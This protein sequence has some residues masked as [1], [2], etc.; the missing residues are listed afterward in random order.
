M[1]C[2]RL[3]V[4]ILSPR[5]P[6]NQGPSAFIRRRA[7]FVASK[8]TLRQ[9]FKTERLKAP[10]IQEVPLHFSWRRKGLAVKV[11]YPKVAGTLSPKPLKDS[12]IRSL[13]CKPRR[14]IIAPIWRVN[15][16]SFDISAKVDAMSSDSTPPLLS[17]LWGKEAAVNSISRPFCNC[18]MRERNGKWPEMKLHTEEQDTSCSAWVRLLELIEQ[19]AN[20]NREEFSPSREMTPEQW[21]QIITLPPS[22]AKLKAVKHFILYGSSLVTI[23]PEIG[24]MT[25]LEEFSPYTS[26][27]LHWFPYEITRCRNLIRSTVSTR[28]VYGNYKYRPPFP[29]LPQI[30]KSFAPKN[31]SVCNSPLGDLTPMQFWVSLRLATDVL[32]LLVHACSKECLEKIPTPPDSYIQEPHQGGLKLQQPPAK[33]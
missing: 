1:G 32:P 30:H 11:I 17:N 25:S 13:T 4:Q 24:E 20:D 22:I 15:C 21:T 9:R 18:L 33:W 14:F 28:A 5:L 29:K 12:L 2:R 7:F 26:Y 3:Q 16:K 8:I 31:C 6:L 23:P 19:A 27:R 10:V